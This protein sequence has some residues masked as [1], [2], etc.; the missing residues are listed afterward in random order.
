MIVT[1]G[2][3]IFAV[4]ITTESFGDF[5]DGLLRFSKAFCG[6]ADRLDTI[7]TQICEMPQISRKE[8]LLALEEF[9]SHIEDA[10]MQKGIRLT[11]DGTDP[12]RSRDIP[13]TELLHVSDDN[14]RRISF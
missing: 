6:T 5:A 1:F 8:G 3:S 10:Y 7:G 11:I 12:E 14:R 2:G 9:S 4:L 13:G